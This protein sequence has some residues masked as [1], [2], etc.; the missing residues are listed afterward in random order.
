VR[1]FHWHLMQLEEMNDEKISASAKPARLTVWEKK[2]WSG[3]GIII[4]YCIDTMSESM[5]SNHADMVSEINRWRY[6]NA[7]RI[8]GTDTEQ[9]RRDH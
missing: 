4:K 2:N 9:K 5:Y 6:R 7:K 3:G 1:A 8:R